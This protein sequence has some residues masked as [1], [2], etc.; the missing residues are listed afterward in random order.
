MTKRSGR[1]AFLPEL[2]VGSRKEGWSELSTIG[3]T[4]NIATISTLAVQKAQLKKK[5]KLGLPAP[6]A[7]NVAKLQ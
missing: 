4:S 1:R 6:A 5:K 2:L 7:L 3:S